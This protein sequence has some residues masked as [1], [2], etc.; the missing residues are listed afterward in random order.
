[1]TCITLLKSKS[2]F[3]LNVK[4]CAFAN[5]TNTIDL[6][7]VLKDECKSNVDLCLLKNLDCESLRIEAEMPQ[8]RMSSISMNTNVAR[9]KL[10]FKMASRSINIEG[11]KTSDTGR[12]GR[13]MLARKVNDNLCQ[14]VNK[15]L[16][17]C[18]SL[19]L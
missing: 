17:P 16:C 11:S 9:S 13:C 19:P 14:K 8:N 10:S 4:I 18:K 5:H 12:L 1:M 7:A 3:S 15:N 6:L 2:K